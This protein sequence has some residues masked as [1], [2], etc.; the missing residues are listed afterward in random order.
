MDPKHSDEHLEK[1]ESLDHAK[2]A[3]LAADGTRNWGV[4]KSLGVWSPA[5][6]YCMAIS[7]AIIWERCGT[8]VL[9]CGAMC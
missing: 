9:L 6:F 1:L 2:D 4:K 8:V 5:V 3:H 7:I